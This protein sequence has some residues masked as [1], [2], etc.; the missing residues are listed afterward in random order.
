MTGRSHDWS[1][2][3]KSMPKPTFF[4]L[5]DDKRQRLIDLAIEEFAEN[6]YD[7][8]SISKIVAQAGIAKGSF[9][10]YFEDKK[11]LYQYLLE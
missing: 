7:L 5:T 9:Y 3:F 8:A 10:Q 11:D 2:T 6:D 1:V 4:N